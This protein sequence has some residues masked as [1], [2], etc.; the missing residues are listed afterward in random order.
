MKIRG[1]PVD[2]LCNMELTYRNYVTRERGEKVLYVHI[3]K[4]IYG[5]LVSA[6]LFYNKFRASLEKVGFECNPYDPCIA[7]KI[8]NGKQMTIVWHVD[9]LKSSHV[10]PRVNDLFVSWLN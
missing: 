4:A 10:D 6:I 9:D 5:L 8:V 2:I 3:L 1:I 7:N